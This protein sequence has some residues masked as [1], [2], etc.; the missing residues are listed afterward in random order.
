MFWPRV[1]ANVTRTWDRVTVASLHLVLL[2]L[3]PLAYASPPDPLWIAG[4]YDAADYDDVITIA[5]GID[6]TS[7]AMLTIEQPFSI[8]VGRLLHVT[9]VV[10]GRAPLKA[11][12][13]RAPPSA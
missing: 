2:A 13:V 10:L 7:M 4:I 11:P 12:S 9:P 5:S 6:G 1:R 8:T 3:V